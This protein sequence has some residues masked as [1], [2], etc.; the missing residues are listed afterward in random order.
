MFSWAAT[1]SKLGVTISTFC[2]KQEMNLSG[3]SW[4]L[5]GELTPVFLVQPWQTLGCS[6]RPSS[7]LL[8]EPWTQE[9]WE[10]IVILLIFQDLSFK[11]HNMGSPDC[12]LSVSYQVSLSE[13]WVSICLCTGKTAAFCNAQVMAGRRQNVTNAVAGD[14]LRYR[15]CWDTDG[16]KTSLSF[17]TTATLRLWKLSAKN[18]MKQKSF[19]RALNNWCKKEPFS[20]LQELPNWW[21]HARKSCRTTYLEVLST[22]WKHNAEVNM[23]PGWVKR[24]FVGR[25]EDWWTNVPAA[26]FLLG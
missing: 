15:H 17:W 3:R 2:K 7:N 6:L 8:Q 11:I 10:E 23:S 5:A 19:T 20:F 18:V 25:S 24:L 16:W 4:V 12:I 14:S 1:L 21:V 26:I 13:E 22:A 9:E